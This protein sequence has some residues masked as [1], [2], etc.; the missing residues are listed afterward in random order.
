[1]LDNVR[2]TAIRELSYE[3][4]HRPSGI[5]HRPD[6]L[7]T[8]WKLMGPL[9]RADAE[10]EQAADPLTRTIP[11]RDTSHEWIDFRTDARGAVVTG[12]VV[13]FHG[14]RTVAYFLTEVGVPDGESARLE[15]SSIDDLAIWV[16]GRFEG[17]AY[18]DA[19]AWHDFGRNPDHRPTAAVALSTGINRVLVRVRGG[20]YASGGFFARMVR[21]PR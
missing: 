16:N 21:A 15:F 7:Q 4:P 9:S 19:L 2:A 10:L 1:L 17:Y 3:G 20:V 12:R 14:D 8:T 13:D 6:L 11:D 5:D 18:R